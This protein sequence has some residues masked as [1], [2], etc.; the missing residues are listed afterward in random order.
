MLYLADN[1]AYFPYAVQDEPL[2]IMYQIDVLVTHTGS[3]LMVHFREGLKPNPN[4]PAPPQPHQQPHLQLFQN[5]ANNGMADGNG[6]ASL[7]AALDD[8]DD[9]DKD[10]FYERLPDDT[11]ELQK[12][13]RSAQ[14]CMLLLLLKQHLKE[15]Y[16]I[17][18]CKITR[19]SPS[20]VNKAYDKSMQRKTVPIFEPQS[21]IELIRSGE[22]VTAALDETGKRQLIDRYFEVSVKIFRF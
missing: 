10:A 9:D 2:Y 7:H 12:C 4:A 16:G 22:T 15:M 13:V 3:T 20:E 14:G 17:T 18:D 11:T 8:E 5:Q 6:M 21:T 1:L 19:Y